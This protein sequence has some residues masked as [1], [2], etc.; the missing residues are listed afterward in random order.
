MSPQIVLPTA[1]F[2]NLA[3]FSFLLSEKALCIEI[4]EHFIKQSIRNRFVIASPQGALPLSIPLVNSGNKTCAGE[5][6][7]SYQEPWQTKY[8][9]AIESAYRN[10]PY[11]EYFE[12]EIKSAFFSKH[13]LLVHYNETILHAVF[14][15]LRKSVALT[16]T[17]S[18]QAN[19]E[20]DFR[21]EKK[22]NARINHFPEYYQVFKPT[23]GFIPNLSILDL[24]FNEGL[25]SVNYL[26]NL[27]TTD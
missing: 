18:Y 13:E 2:P 21:D 27:K 9:R 12:E 11:F 26:L 8:W 4:H 1:F 14:N 6:L 5:K 22:I 25:F 20:L 17:T 16:T 23:T 3:Y 24:L 19:Y 15:V 7:I 10:S